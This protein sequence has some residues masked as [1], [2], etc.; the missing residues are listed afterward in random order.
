MHSS[1]S[2]ILFSLR[3]SRAMATTISETYPLNPW[4]SAASQLVQLFQ[5]GIP[6]TNSACPAPPHAMQQLTDENA[7]SSASMQRSFPNPGHAVSSNILNYVFTSVEFPSLVPCS[8]HTTLLQPL[9]PDNILNLSMIV[10]TSKF[11]LWI[12]F[13]QKNQM[14]I[15]NLLSK[16]DLEITVPNSAL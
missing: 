11:R 7:S 9:C 10:I 4:Y 3:S 5:C 2:F 16:K 12:A 8:T 15:T 1:L 13:V 6:T 14:F